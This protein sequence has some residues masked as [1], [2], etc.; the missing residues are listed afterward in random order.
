MLKTAG[1]PPT[2]GKRTTVRT[3]TTSGRPTIAGTPTTVQHRPYNSRDVDNGRNS[4]NRSDVNISRTPS[5]AEMQ[6]TAG[7]LKTAG[8]PA[9]ILATG[10]GG[11][12]RR[13]ETPGLDGMSTTG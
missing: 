4:R 2:A 9:G 7:M 8:T 1:T 3:P 5:T 11:A 13:V 6:T 10:G 12:T